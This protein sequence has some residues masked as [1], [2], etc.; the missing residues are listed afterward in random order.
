MKGTQMKKVIIGISLVPTFMFSGCHRDTEKVSETRMV[1]GDTVSQAS[2]LK[3][4]SV[5]LVNEFGRPFCSGSL[6][7]NRKTVVTAGHCF[8]PL[9]GFN[10]EKFYVYFGT[11]VRNLSYKDV[12]AKD[13]GLEAPVRPLN[14]NDSRIREIEGIILHD[15]FDQFAF[16]YGV[17]KVEPGE[18]AVYGSFGKDIAIV[19]LDKEAPESHPTIEILPESEPLTANDQ[20]TVLGYGNGWNRDGTDVVKGTLQ[21]IE[22]TIKD[23]SKKHS[24]MLVEGNNEASTFHTDSGGPVLV[25]RNGK[26]YQVGLT[27]HPNKHFHN[28]AEY[29]AAVQNKKALPGGVVY[30]LVR[31]YENWIKEQSAKNQFPMFADVISEPMACE[32][33]DVQCESGKFGFSAYGAPG[34]FGSRAIRFNTYQ[35][36]DKD[37]EIFILGG[38][39]FGIRTKVTNENKDLLL[40]DKTIAFLDKRMLVRQDNTVQPEPEPEPVQKTCVINDNNDTFVH[41]RDPRGTVVASIYNGM[42]VKKIAESSGRVLVELKGFV[43][44][45]NTTCSNGQCGNAFAISDDAPADLGQAL[46]TILRGGASSSQKNLGIVQNFTRVTKTDVQGSWLGISFKGSIPSSMCR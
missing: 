26:F 14:D 27:S 3:D 1:F 33:G 6:V 44:S 13:L 37:L 36:G 19:K 8:D 43:H 46:G 16:R 21:Y 17:A 4:K 22:G 2:E 29:D 10:V 9:S 41:V 12:P 20:V 7:H 23:I 34:M 39:Y 28:Q 30:T 31:P 45:S 35:L 5:L 32:E 15:R 11:D 18:A 42:E 25:K 38:S 40:G 24:E